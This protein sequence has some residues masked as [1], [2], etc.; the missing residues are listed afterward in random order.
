MDWLIFFI[1]A[2]QVPAESARG[3]GDELRPEAAS[4]R[5]K[6]NETQELDKKLVNLKSIEEELETL[7]AIAKTAARDDHTA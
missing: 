7:K 2:A 3:A 6:E 4:K 1:I 5:P